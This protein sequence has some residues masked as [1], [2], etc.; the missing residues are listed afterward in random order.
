MTG[1]RPRHT[2]EAT[3][4]VAPEALRGELTAAQRAAKHGIRQTVV[5]HW[6]R[7]AVEG[8]G[9]EAAPPRFHA[10][11]SVPRRAYSSVRRARTSRLPTWLAGPTMPSFSICSISL[12][13]RL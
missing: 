11:G 5:G 1:K 6:K 3:A 4:K 9:E 10:S 13:A 2:A 8:S 12:A 7:Q